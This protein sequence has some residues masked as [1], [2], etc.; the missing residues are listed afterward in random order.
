MD[1]HVLIALLLAVG[2]TLADWGL[3]VLRAFTTGTFSVQKLPG[4]L[5]SMFLPYILPLFATD[6]IVQNG[7]T[8][9]GGSVVAYIA[10]GTYGAKVLADILSK[11]Q[12]FGTAPAA[13]TKL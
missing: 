12:A 3:G 5:V 6:L 1:V 9:W 7:I 11:L 10:S 4:Q 13:A 2:L 8:G